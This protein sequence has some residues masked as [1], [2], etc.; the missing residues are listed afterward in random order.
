MAAGWAR[1]ATYEGPHWDDARRERGDTALR[2]DV[3]FERIFDPEIDEILPLDRLRD[4][5]LASVNWATP[6]SGIQI[7]QGVEGLERLWADLV[8]RYDAA[9]KVDEDPGAMEGEVRIAL[10]R[11]RARERW[12]RDEKLAQAKAANA[13]RLPCQV[14]GFDFF[15]VYGEPGRDYAQV[16]HFKPLSDR[17]RPSLTRLED[18]AVLCANC[19]VMIHRG[20]GNLALE[21]LLKGPVPQGGNRPPGGPA[22]S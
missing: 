20:G 21:G 13:G 5:P 14:C 6:A 3:G 10:T 12:L 22:G 1:S 16:H 4:G 18:L 15:E 9:R 11:H 19:H 8:G 7:R 17:T 2:V